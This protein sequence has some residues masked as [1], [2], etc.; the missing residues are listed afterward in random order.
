M[1]KQ[2]VVLRLLLLLCVAITLSPRPVSAMH[3]PP[4]VHTDLHMGIRVYSFPLVV[5][6]LEP[7]AYELRVYLRTICTKGPDVLIKGFAGAFPVTGSEPKGLSLFNPHFQPP[8]LQQRKLHITSKAAPVRCG[9]SNSS[10]AGAKACSSGSGRSS[11]TVLSWRGPANQGFWRLDGKVKPRG[12][13]VLSLEGSEHVHQLL[14]SC[15]GRTAP[16]NTSPFPAVGLWN[17][18]TT[19]SAN[20]L[21]PKTLAHLLLLHMQYHERLGVAGTVLRCNKGEAQDLAV[22]PHIET[23]VAQGKLLLW[24]W[25]SASCVRLRFAVSCACM[26]SVGVSGHVVYTLSI[27]FNKLGAMPGGVWL[28]VFVTR[29]GSHSLRAAKD[30]ASLSA[31][32]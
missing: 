21:P 5:P 26:L 16:A 8:A 20:S 12:V 31:L 18:V 6:E 22:L 11:S 32:A 15:N 23:L 17:V 19:T 1:A 29:R 27:S 4:S 7:T 28:P 30:S 25:V 3:T 24:P 14:L 2:L 13:E 10:S 9:S